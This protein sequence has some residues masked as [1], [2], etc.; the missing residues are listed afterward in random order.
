METTRLLHPC[1]NHNPML[2]QIA[3]PCQADW[4]EMRQDDAGRHC[5]E[6]SR[7]VIDFTGM[8]AEEIGV[9]W[10][11]FHSKG[12]C[13]RFTTDQLANPI[14]SAENYVI[15]VLKSPLPFL[16]QIAALII[17]ALFIGVNAVSAQTKPKAEHAVQ[18]S[19]SSKTVSKAGKISQKAP[20]S[21]KP[22]VLQ[23]P[24]SPAPVHIMGFVAMAPEA[25]TARSDS[26]TGSKPGK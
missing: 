5:S 17:F 12:I 6:C 22:A 1:V 25:R 26:S 7:T 13:G 3:K 15:Q 4:N 24:A 9:Y 8:S 18:K 16:R 11:L 21:S 23:R 10:Q 20:A 14:S 19:A 2:L